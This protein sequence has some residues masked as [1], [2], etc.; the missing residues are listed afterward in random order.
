MPRGYG[1]PQ[2]NGVWR[3]L[4]LERIP[5]ASPSLRYVFGRWRRAARA[6][7][8]PPRWRRSAPEQ[9]RC[10]RRR[11]RMCACRSSLCPTLSVICQARRRWCWRRSTCSSCCWP[12]FCAA[13]SQCC[14]SPAPS[15]ESGSSWFAPHSAPAVGASSCNLCR[16]APALRRRRGGWSHGCALRARA[17]LD[18]DRRANG[19][20][21]VLY[22]HFAFDDDD[23]LCRW[24]DAVRGGDRRRRSRVKVTSGGAGARLRAASSGGGLQFGGVW[25]VVIVVQIAFTTLLPWPL[26]G[27]GGDFCGRDTPAGFPAEA[28][29]TATLEMDRFDGVA[30]SGDTVPAVRAVRTRSTLPRARRPAPTGPG[31]AGRHVRRSNAAALP[32]ISRD[33]DGPGSGR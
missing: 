15:V 21:A 31:R 16:G 29:L 28:F 22:R 4:H 13:T 26:L 12:R 33:R 1:F 18:D 14:C 8:R 9:R 24:A 7:K 20:V 23:S 27:L 19:S 6:R 2:R 10:F 25:T 32:V 11:A 5:E 30:A 3:P 17:D